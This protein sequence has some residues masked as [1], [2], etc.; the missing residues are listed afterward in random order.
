MLNGFLSLW[1][2]CV[3]GFHFLR[4][5]CFNQGLYMVLLFQDMVSNFYLGWV[6]QTR[7]LAV[8]LD[9]TFALSPLPMIHTSSAKGNSTYDFKVA[10]TSWKCWALSYLAR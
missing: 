6:G 4:H 5:F 3:R 9:D 7:L 8:A 1:R 10:L 2:R